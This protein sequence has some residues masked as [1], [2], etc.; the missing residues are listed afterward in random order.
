MPDQRNQAELDHIEIRNLIQ[1]LG[2]AHGS[3][4]GQ[5]SHVLPSLLQ[6]TDQVVDGQHDVGDQLVLGHANIANS[7]THAQDLLQL[8]LDG[9]LD[10][11]N[12][13]GEIFVVGDRGREFTGLGQTG[14]KKTRNLLDQAVG[15]DEGVVLARKL[16]DQLLVLV[17]LLQVVG[18]HGVDAEMLR[19]VDIVLVTKNAAAQCQYC[20]SRCF[21]SRYLDYASNPKYGRCGVPDG[22]VWSRNGG[23][24]D[25]ARETLVTLR[26]I[27]LQA[28]LEFDGLEEVS[29][30]LVQR[31]IEKLLH[32]LAHSG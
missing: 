27:V 26:V 24:L 20:F 12:L 2:R 16:L 7:D 31:V 6:Q 28:D 4:D 15:G 14:T 11:G 30:L 17:Q 25:G 23:Q 19:S 18:R 5:A 22:H 13:C 8:E 3:L 21:L 1:S 9:G 10:L 29:L 32:V